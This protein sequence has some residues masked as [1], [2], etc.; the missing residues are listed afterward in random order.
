MSEEKKFFLQNVKIILSPQE[1]DW[2]IKHITDFFDKWGVRWGKLYAPYHLK[3]GDYTFEILGKDYRNEF[4][5]ERKFGVEELYGCVTQ[6]NIMTKAKFELADTKLRDNLE[7]ELERMRQV[8]VKEKWLFIENCSSFE[9]IKNWVSGYEQKNCTHGSI[10]Y[11]TISSWAAANRYDLRIECCPTKSEVGSTMLSKMYY[12]WRND[13]KI[14]FGQ[15]F[16]AKARA[17]LKQV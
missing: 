6:R 10:V 9:S 13:M 1:K 17:L 12:Y 5:I 2:A 16:L 14:Q 4:L 3:Q 8:G 11:S 15:N 7:Y